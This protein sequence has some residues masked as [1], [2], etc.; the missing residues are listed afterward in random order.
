MTDNAIVRL[1]RG[2]LMNS[3]DEGRGKQEDYCSR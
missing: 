2:V 1:I 3:G